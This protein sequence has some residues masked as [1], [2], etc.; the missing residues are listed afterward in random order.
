SSLFFLFPKF[1]KLILTLFVLGIGI[2]LFGSV[3]AQLT[4]IKNIPGDYATLASAI[5]DLNS[6]GV[7]P[8]GVTINL[9]A[10]NPETAPIEGYIITTLTGSM[11]NPIIIQGNG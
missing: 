6:S 1:L 3:S 10:G 8:G 7:G 9:L 5:S 11:A 2:F 4:G